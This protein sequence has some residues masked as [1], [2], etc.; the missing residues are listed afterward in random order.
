VDEAIALVKYATQQ[1][2]TDPTTGL[3]DMDVIVTG[4]TSSSRNKAKKIKEIA[5][6]IIK[7]NVRMFKKNSTIDSIRGD[8]ERKMEVGEK[9]SDEEML[10]GLRILESEGIIVMFGG[11]KQR[12]NFRLARDLHNL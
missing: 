6:E 8:V 5:H 4:K 7:A 12:P 10:D 1:A 9:V 3:I 2:A 11:N